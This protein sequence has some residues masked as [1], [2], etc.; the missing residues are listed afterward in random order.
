MGT[1]G[2][3]VDDFVRGQLRLSEQELLLKSAC[4][5]LSQQFPGAGEESRTQP[6]PPPGSAIITTPFR[7]RQG[8]SRD[9]G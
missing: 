9:E 8:V 4:V 3:S 2:K 6:Q 7:H 5:V 1:A